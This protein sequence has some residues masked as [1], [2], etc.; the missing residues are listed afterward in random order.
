[1]LNVDISELSSNV[2]EDHTWWCQL[3]E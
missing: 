1:M 2:T 3:Q